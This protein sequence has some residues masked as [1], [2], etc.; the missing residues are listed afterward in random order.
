MNHLTG[1]E[2]PPASLRHGVGRS[3][4]PLDS[5]WLV[6]PEGRTLLLASCWEQ[7]V[8]VEVNPFLHAPPVSP[9]QLVEHRRLGLSGCCW[10]S[11]GA[12]DWDSPWLQ[13]GE[14]PVPCQPS[15][16]SPQRSRP[17]GVPHLGCSAFTRQEMFELHGVVKL[18]LPLVVNQGRAAGGAEDKPGAGGVHPGPVHFQPQG[19]SW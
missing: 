8:L 13:A 2:Q 3:S 17:G 4:Y 19:H 18:F 9:L 6:C 15:C 14:A 12:T 5:P 7:L 1:T 16:A 11:P 10:G